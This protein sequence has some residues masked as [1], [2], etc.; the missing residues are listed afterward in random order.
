LLRFDIA[1][2]ITRKFFGEEKHLIYY[3]AALNVRRWAK[4]IKGWSKIQKL[5]TEW[6]SRFYFGLALI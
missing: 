4:V 3:F 6:R 2:L 1:A 5:T